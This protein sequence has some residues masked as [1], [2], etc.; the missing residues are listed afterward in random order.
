MITPGEQ[1][2]V[3]DG[4]I[5][6]SEAVNHPHRSLLIESPEWGANE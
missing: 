1:F 5:S 6:E 2:L 4:K 3:D